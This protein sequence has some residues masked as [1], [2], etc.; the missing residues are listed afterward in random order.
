MSLL[1]SAVLLPLLRAGEVLDPKL[2][3]AARFV[4]GT[5]GDGKEREL[6]LQKRG[7]V[8]DGFDNEGSIQAEFASPATDAQ[9]LKV[10]LL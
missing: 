4:R 3:G 10:R 1:K 7:R 8:A 9:E 5:I 6:S 2:Y